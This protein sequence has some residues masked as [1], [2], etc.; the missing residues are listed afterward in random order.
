MNRYQE[1]GKEFVSGKFQNEKKGGQ[2]LVDEGKNEKITKELVIA[3]IKYLIE[4]RSLSQDEYVNGL[5]SI[6]CD[7]T[8]TD[9]M[10]QF[11]YNIDLTRGICIGDIGCGAIILVNSKN[12][13]YSRDI[14]YDRFLENDDS[15]SLYHYIRTLTKNFDYTKEYVDNFRRKK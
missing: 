8:I 1:W 9:V 2:N 10:R 11:N 6:G 3:G 5:N 12:S 15:Y 14:I 7:F 4:N 13:E